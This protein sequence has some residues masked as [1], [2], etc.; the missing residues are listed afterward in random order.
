MKLS[1]KLPVQGIRPCGSTRCAS[2][3]SYHWSARNP[4]SSI[5]PSRS[6]AP[7]SAVVSASASPVAARRRARACPPSRQRQ[8]RELRGRAGVGHVHREPR[9]GPELG[10]QAAHPGSPDDA[11]AH[12]AARLPGAADPQSD[13]QGRAHT[14]EGGHDR[15]APRRGTPGTRSPAPTRACPPGW[16]RP[17]DSRPRRRTCPRQAAPAHPGRPCRTPPGPPRRAAPRRARGAAR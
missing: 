1:V 6:A 11:G 12:G 7:P 16:T 15:Q 9:F 14:P 2:R 3:K 10:D 17:P 13:A 8:P 4:A 5:V